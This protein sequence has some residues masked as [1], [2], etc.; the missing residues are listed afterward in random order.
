[1][2]TFHIAMPSAIYF[3]HVDEFCSIVNCMFERTFHT[4]F[5]PNKYHQDGV[6][7]VRWP[8]GLG[9]RVSVERSAKVRHDMMTPEYSLLRNA[10]TRLQTSLASHIQGSTMRNFIFFTVYIMQSVIKTSKL[11]WVGHAVR[12]EQGR[13]AYKI[14]TGKLEGKRRLGRPRRS[15]IQEGFTMQNFILCTVLL[16]QSG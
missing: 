8:T 3:T 11:R 4:S 7:F 1:M 2:N 13:S 6:G 10:S 16:V 5:V 9:L 15:L 12:M 14:V